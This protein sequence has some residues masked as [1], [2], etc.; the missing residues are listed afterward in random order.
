MAS[1]YLLEIDGI[2]GD[3]QD[4]KHKETIEVTNFGWGASNSGS[5]AHGAGGGSGKVSAQNFHFS[6]H[7][8]KASPLIL[9]RCATGEHI[10]KA[11]LYV[12]KAGKDQLDYYIWKFTDLLI[13][14]YQTHGGGAELPQ[15]EISFDCAQLE[16]N[17]SPQKNDGTLGSPI[18]F[19]YDFQKSQSPS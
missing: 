16:I 2:K 15:E 14:S 13:T 3:S 18:V 4:A 11:T 19:K 17:Y 1:D 6:T 9:G 7:V 12:R 8:S 10:K 5:F